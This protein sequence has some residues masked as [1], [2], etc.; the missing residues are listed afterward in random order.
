MVSHSDILAVFFSKPLINYTINKGN[1]HCCTMHV[2]SIFSLL[3]QLM[4]FTAL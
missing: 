1:L 4:H 3:F 2:V